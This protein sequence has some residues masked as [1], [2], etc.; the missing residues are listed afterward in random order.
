[1]S[2][3]QLYQGWEQIKFLEEISVTLATQLA[4]LTENMRDDF[5]EDFKNK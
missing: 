1:M 5:H 4:I 2:A 3:I